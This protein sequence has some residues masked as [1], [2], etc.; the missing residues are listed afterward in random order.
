MCNADKVYFIQYIATCIHLYIYYQK[1]SLFYDDK[2]YDNIALSKTLK[3]FTFLKIINYI[4]MLYTII[5]E[6]GDRNFKEIVY[7]Q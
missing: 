1:L 2:R 5:N 4:K 6:Y 3:H 7:F